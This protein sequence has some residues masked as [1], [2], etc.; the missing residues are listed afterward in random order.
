MFQVNF[1][2]Y[3]ISNADRDTIYRPKG[4][5]DYLFLLI[6]SPME[7]K[8][9][10]LSA[11]A[12]PGACVLYTPGHPQHYQ[13]VRGFRNS[14][15]HFSAEPGDLA[16]Y[17]IPENT[18][19]YP[20]SS[21]ELNSLLKQIYA[22]YLTKELHY[23]K[24]LDSLVTL[25]AVSLSRRINSI[26]Q[27]GNQEMALLMS[28]Q[29]AR[30][31]ILSQCWEDWNTEKMCGLVHM[32]KSQFYSYYKMFFHNSPKAELLAARLDYAKNLLT[33][34]SMQVQQ[35]AELSGFH[36]VTHFTNYFKEACGCTPKEYIAKSRGNPEPK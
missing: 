28:F 17:Q 33:N 7:F 23:Q 32:G 30:L 11:P 20:G 5:G 13:A 4:S 2:G 18:V 6:Q 35:A 10:K 31:Q 3:N 19:F 15:V 1:C 24:R 25:L 22:E 27:H 12:K 36:S 21:D 9:P 16:P 29:K 26:S 8:A 14:Y 34:E